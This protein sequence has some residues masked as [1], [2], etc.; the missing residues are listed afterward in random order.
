MCC[1]EVYSCNEL[2]HKCD[3]VNTRNNEL[4]K[5]KRKEFN[6]IVVVCNENAT[7]LNDTREKHLTCQVKLG[8]VDHEC[9]KLEQGLKC[10]GS[11]CK[12]Y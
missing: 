1:K 3:D 10:K 7:K 8:E 5:K 12:R 11:R 4:V 9:E 6:K 2:V